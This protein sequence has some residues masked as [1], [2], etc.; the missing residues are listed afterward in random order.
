MIILLQGPP[1][2]GKTTLASKLSKELGILHISKDELKETFF[3]SIGCDD[4]ELSRKLGMVSNKILFKI[5]EKASNNSNHI[6][7]ESNFDPELGKIDLENAIKGKQINV[8]EIFLSAPN[9]TLISRFENRWNSGE[10]HRG[11]VDNLRFGDLREFLEE[12]PRP[13]SISN[14]IIEIC[15]DNSPEAVF[16]EAFEKINIFV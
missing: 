8:V 7:I 14:N 3:D 9:E 2:S 10:R 13:I 12:K 11:H 1:G 16:Q 15:T 4:P 5:I 6:M